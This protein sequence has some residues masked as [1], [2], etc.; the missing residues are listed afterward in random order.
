MS[1]LKSLASQTAVYG[2]SSILG[3]MLNYALVPLHTYYFQDTESLGIVNIYYGVVAMLLAVF[4]FGMETTFFRFANKGDKA[5]VFGSTRTAVLFI[6]T[7]ITVPIFLF[8]PQIAAIAG[9]QGTELFIRWLI[10]TLWLDAFMAIPFALMRFENQARFFATAKVIHIFISVGMQVFVFLVVPWLRD[11]GYEVGWV[12]DLGIGYI[13]LA[14]LVANVILFL[15]IRKWVFRYP[16]RWPGWQ[17]FSPLLAYA[18]PIMLTGFAGMI[19]EQVDTVMI[20]GFLPDGFYGSSEALENPTAAAGVYKQT[21]KLSVIIMLGIQAFRYA[22]EPFFFS[23]AKD[24]NAPELFARVMHYFTIVCLLILVLVSVNVDLIAQIFLRRESYRVALYI[25]PILLTGKLFYGIYMNLSIW[26]KLTDKTIYG[27]YF[28][29]L[30]AGITI[31]GNFLLIPVI[32][33]VGSAWTSVACYLVMAIVCYYYGQKYYPIP[34]KFIALSGY[35]LISIL[36]I[37]LSENFHYQDFWM[38]AAL[39]ILISV[40]LVVLLFFRERKKLRKSGIKV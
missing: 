30:G 20:K 2:V 18:V 17:A 8:A 27:M 11:S 31:L 14:N 37:L 4:T 28:S 9:Y 33:F 6:S 39:R 40:I 25:V 5:E 24:K 21:F 10:I 16:L 32:G 26:F 12:P 36:L 38:D 23:Q 19:N 3:R 29:L 22:G 13:F 34:Y 1:K 7:L 15:I 35:F